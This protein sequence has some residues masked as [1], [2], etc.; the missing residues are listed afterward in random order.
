MINESMFRGNLAGGVPYS[1][2]ANNSG[3]PVA[4]QNVGVDNGASSGGGASINAVNNM[5]SVPV[6]SLYSDPSRN[7]AVLSGIGSSLIGYD[8]YNRPIYSRGR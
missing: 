3:V 1:S 7:S 4:T 2:G 8:Q 6:N 5:P